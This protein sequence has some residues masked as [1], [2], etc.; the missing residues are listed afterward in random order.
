M[1]TKAWINSIF[2]V[3]IRFLKF[4]VLHVD[5][6]PHRIALGVSLGL[7]IAYMPPLGF[8]ILLLIF[9]SIIFK[10]NKF[11]ALTFVWVSNP[12]TIFLLY[13][14]SYLIGRTILTYLGYEDGFAAAEISSLFHQY[15]SFEHVVSGFFTS[16]FWRQMGSLIVQTGLE[17]FIGGLI[18]G[19]FVAV[20]A[21]FA[22]YY[23]IC[24]YRKKHPHHTYRL[25]PKL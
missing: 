20:T 11:V 24:W 10:A 2:S 8:H 13:Y 21:Y 6:S 16:Q 4:R 15:L 9:L 22:A 19:T 18:L 25:Q 1:I 17:M 12:F 7:F 5:D 23:C 14:P 3:V